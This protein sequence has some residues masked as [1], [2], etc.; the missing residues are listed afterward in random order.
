[1]LLTEFDRA[2]EWAEFIAGRNLTNS[3]VAELTRDYNQWVSD[4][5]RSN[6]DS[7]ELYLETVY[8]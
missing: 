2:R 6:V 3:E 5:E 8:E 4:V 1:M 7:V